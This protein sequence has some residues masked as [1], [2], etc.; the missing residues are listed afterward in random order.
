MQEGPG[1]LLYHIIRK[2]LSGALPKLSQIKQDI[3]KAE[4]KVFKQKKYTQAVTK[5]ADIQRDIV[6]FQQIFEPHKIV[7]ENLT[8]EAGH[9]FDKAM[10]PYFSHLINLYKQV[11][12]IAKSRANALGY[13]NETNQSL[14]T[15]KTNEIIKILTIFSVV[16]FPM[17]FLANFFGMN[18]DTLPFGFLQEQHKILLI[19]GLMGASTITFLLYFTRKKWR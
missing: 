2:I 5:I 7:L 19:L 3:E 18:I 12:I 10:S 16:V 15:T 17:T 6:N 8:R 13:L 1:Q 14:L 11:E 9:I 4:D